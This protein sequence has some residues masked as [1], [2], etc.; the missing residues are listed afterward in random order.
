MCP[1]P[2]QRIY[3]IADLHL[4]T[5]NYA[6]WELLNAFLPT[7]A[8]KA[9]ALYILGDLFDAW[10]GDDSLQDQH[11]QQVSQALRQL[12]DS[13]IKLYFMH[14]N[15]DFLIGD[16]FAQAT[17]GLLLAEEFLLNLA[18]KRLLLLHG[19]QL[20][21]DDLAYQEFRHKVRCPSWQQEFLAQPIVKRRELVQEMRESS[22]Y[23]KSN[24]TL[25]IMDANPAT[26]EFFFQKHAAE[27]IIHGHTHK[28]AMFQHGHRQRWVLPDWPPGGGVLAEISSDSSDLKLSKFNV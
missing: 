7:L 20:C 1:E 28:P 18:D 15:R 24:K 6:A 8:A 3:F 12:T 13:G 19:D 17:C 22:V 26:I 21:T 11:P 23:E 14:G 4:S 27:I 9:D 10:I 2:I 5:S 16:R 25:E